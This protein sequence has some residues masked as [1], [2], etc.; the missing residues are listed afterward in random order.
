MAR[1][2]LV[3]QENVQVAV[4]AL[5]AEGIA[6]TARAV[7][8]KLGK[9][10]SMGTVHKLLQQCLNVKGNV[11]ESLRQ[12]PPSLQLAILSF[13]DQQVADARKEIADELLCCK[14][15]ASE[16]AGANDQITDVVAE[17]R[18]QLARA[19]A[20]KAAVEGRLAQQAS[21]L[22]AVRHEA[23][24]ERQAAE[25]ARTDLAK[26]QLRLDML[27]PLEGELH[28]VRTQHDAQRNACKSAEQTAAVLEIQK[29]ALE[30]QVAEIKSELADARDICR[31]RGEK[32]EKLSERVEAERERRME[33]EQKLAV[34]EATN[35]ARPM[36][37]GK[38]RKGRGRQQ[39]LWHGD[40]H[41]G[42]TSRE[43]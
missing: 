23:A 3:T 34:F 8:D 27:E 11:A 33:A 12:L 21:E 22:S 1:Q 4:E 14:K 7:H 13:A 20:D 37:D 42:Q 29:A 18:E 41:E 5:R 24:A 28:D 30:I 9:V 31:Q 2:A 6:P 26:L 39:D 36:A 25:T 38:V 32:I 40:V 15:E 10:G 19:V 35:A 16:L 43:P 17:L